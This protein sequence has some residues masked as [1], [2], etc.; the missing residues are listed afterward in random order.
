MLMATP[1]RFRAF[2]A[3]RDG[4]DVH[5]AVASLALGVLPDADLTIRVRWSG[6]NYK[7]GLATL[8]TGKVARISPLV[9]GTDLAGTV[10]ESR[11]PLRPVGSEV[12]AHG[13]ELGMSHHGGF[14]EFARVPGDWTIPLPDGLTPREAMALGTAGFTAARSVDVLER[15]GLRPGQGP[16]LVTGATG[17][18]GGYAVGILAQRG[19]EVWGLTRKRDAHDALRALGAV[20][21]VDPTELEASG[22]ALEKERW[23][24]AID[25]VGQSSLPW[26]L[27][28][29]RYGAAV[30]ATGNVSGRELTTS[31]FPFIL[32]D[33]ALL[34]VDSA[35]VA[36]PERRLIWERLSSDLRPKLLE[37]R[38][39]EIG[40]DGLAQAIATVLAGDARGRYLVRLAG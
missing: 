37:E 27:R 35:S 16:V 10:I 5:C 33:V 6:V 2:V 26:I 21:F 1:E 22:K 34:G 25:T 20:G 30:A 18:V 36:A 8:S 32:R 31:V 9:L 3:T 4:D 23:A 7:D 28:T 17:G 11:D 39:M 29:L 13:H 19:Y 15:R 38:T 24:G 12:I 14:A 40:L